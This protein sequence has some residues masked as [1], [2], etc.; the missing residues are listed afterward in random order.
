MKLAAALAAVLVPAVA[1]AQ[2]EGSSFAERL[3]W[4][5]QRAAVTENLQLQSELLRREVE[6]QQQEA[7]REE[8]RQRL[9][10]ENRRLKKALS[11]LAAA[12]K[13]QQSPPPAH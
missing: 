6:R 2:T 7:R 3:L 11:A 9:E 10:E 1:S 13:A 5:E 8:E 4:S 12:K